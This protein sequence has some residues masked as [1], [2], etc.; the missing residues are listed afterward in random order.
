MLPFGPSKCSSLCRGGARD[1]LWELSSRPPAPS[2][3][4]TFPWMEVP[5]ARAPPHIV[6]VPE[7]G[8]REPLN[9]LSL[10]RRPSPPPPLY[11][12]G[13][14]G[15]CHESPGTSPRCHRGGGLQRREG[16]GRQ[17]NK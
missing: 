12:S 15:S 2:V 1:G 13:S 4:F 8:A 10:W 17:E 7:D 6:A 16:P 5:T 11:E 9:V 14:H 3:T